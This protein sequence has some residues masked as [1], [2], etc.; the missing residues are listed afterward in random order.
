M[1]NILANIKMKYIISFILLTVLLA[2]I[3]VPNIL[4]YIL[5]NDVLIKT[6][7][8]DPRDIFRGDYV[9]L[10]LDIDI[11]SAQNIDEKVVDRII[12]SENYS[13]Y[14]L[15]VYAILK[16]ENNVDIV[17]QIVLLAPKTGDYLNAKID[18]VKYTKDK[19]AI[20]EVI[21]NFEIDK[22]FVEENTGKDLED[23]IREGNAFA[24]LKV[25]NGKAVITEII[26]NE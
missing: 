5:G 14:N 21:L 19:K 1:K 15:Q 6:K 24:K 9:T 8:V 13:Y 4:I 20:E 11:V 26:A 3:A 7:A 25:R 12:D 22:F 10:A 2:T 23:K 16:K 18:Y 17:E